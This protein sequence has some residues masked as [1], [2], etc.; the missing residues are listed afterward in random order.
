[1]TKE[2]LDAAIVKSFL[3]GMTPEVKAGLIQKGI[4]EL[5]KPDTNVYRDQKNQ[6]QRIFDQMVVERMREE[7]RE[8]LKNNEEVKEKIKTLMQEV[9]K[10]LFAYEPDKMAEKIANAFIDS[11]RKDRY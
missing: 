3:D 2:V 6:I 11:F 9:T 1:M 7:V 5:M 10:H 4:E 8:Y